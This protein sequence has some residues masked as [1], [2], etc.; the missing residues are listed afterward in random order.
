M[1]LEKAL[2]DQLSS[3]GSARVAVLAR[4]LDVT[5]ETIRRLA[6]KLDGLI[7]QYDCLGEA[8][9]EIFFVRVSFK[10]KRREVHFL[11]E[12]IVKTSEVANVKDLL[13]LIVEELRDKAI[14]KVDQLVKNGKIPSR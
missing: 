13:Y 6:K 1:S 8:A 3:L 2:L 4:K 5:E 10:A 12:L 11:D 7:G 9:M 14:Q